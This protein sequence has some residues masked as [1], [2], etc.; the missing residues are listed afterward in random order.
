MASKQDLPSWRCIG[1]CLGS[2]AS[3]GAQFWMPENQDH[4]CKSFRITG[5]AGFIG[6]NLVHAWRTARAADRYAIDA[7][8]LASE[9]CNRC[10]VGF[11]SRLKQIVQW[12]LEHEPWWPDVSNGAYKTWIDQNYGFR[13]AV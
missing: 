12:Y 3:R 7:S 13:R 11:E 10:S 5:G 2:V 1:R 6:Q 8:K 4:R 9:L